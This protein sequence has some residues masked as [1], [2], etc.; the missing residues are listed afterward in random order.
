MIFSLGF[1]VFFFKFSIGLAGL[2]DTFVKMFRRLDTKDFKLE[3]L[4]DLLQKTMRI[5]PRQQAPMKMEVVL[6]SQ[7]FNLMYR[8]LDEQQL[9]GLL[10]GRGL[11]DMIAQGVKILRNTV[12]LGG[13]HASARTN[14][15]GIPVM[16]GLASPGFSRSDLAYE[17]V[18][19]DGKFGRSLKA[20]VDLTAQVYTYMV[21]FNPLGI[22]QGITKI[23]GS[24]VHIPANAMFSL[25]PVSKEFKLKINTPTQEMPMSVMFSSKTWAHSTGYNQKKADE[26]LKESCPDC[27]ARSLVTKGEQ[28]RKSKIVRDKDNER[29]GLESRIE[30]I[31]CENY[32]GKHSTGR[33][34]FDSFKPSEI[35]SHGSVAG[36]SLMGF[37][38]LRNYFYHYP[39]IGS[40]T[41][42]AV[43]HRASENPSTAMELRLSADN[44]APGNK[45]ASHGK[46][47]TNVKG[48]MTMVG[49]IERKWKIDVSVEKE[50]MNVKSS[51]SVKIARQ[52]VPALDISSRA[53]C[54]N[55]KTVWAPLP[56][57]DILETPSAI[58]PSVQ[59]DWAFAWGE[60]PTNECPKSGAKG[61]S[62]FSINVVGNITQEQRDAASKRDSYPYNQCDA[63]RVAAGRT[64]TG[65]PMTE[66]GA[67]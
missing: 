36:W 35:N 43:M 44:T 18:S 67:L 12:L 23:R 48:T 66:V 39:P 65:F 26:F 52:P 10:S 5:A 59:R 2:E 9:A 60:A 7:G 29:L 49:E 40:C 34:L 47:F 45:K 55:V 21:A 53:V 31:D 11:A 3:V 6:R 20:D 14:D 27:M 63:D 41:L 51:V 37:M 50:P 61:V 56:E 57:S 8:H 58:E 62:S 30:I 22:Y 4:K 24:R 19:E 54:L 17:S 64:G 38:Q 33:V 28:Y 25:S 15:L 46:T 1:T 42:K 32:K 13:I 16:V